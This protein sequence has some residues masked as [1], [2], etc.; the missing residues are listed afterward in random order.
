MPSVKTTADVTSNVRKN[1][2]RTKIVNKVDDILNRELVRR[3]NKVTIP[4]VSSFT[5]GPSLRDN[6]R[7]KL[8]EH[9]K[10]ANKVWEDYFGIL[11][12]EV[13]W[14]IFEDFAYLNSEVYLGKHVTI[15]KDTNWDDYFEALF[16]LFAK[17]CE[18]NE[19]FKEIPEI[20]FTTT[21]LVYKGKTVT[22]KDWT[23]TVEK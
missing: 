9:Q 6:R 3:A 8:I 12:Q 21:N 19:N 14:D 10:E 11:V 7:G 2:I 15:I 23:L 4:K 13:R 20:P 22:K 18:S 17:P 16:R 1:I 5:D